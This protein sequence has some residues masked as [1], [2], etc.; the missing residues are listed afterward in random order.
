MI[1][2]LIVS[3]LF[4]LFFVWQLQENR[5]IQIKAS[6]KGNSEQFINIPLKDVRKL[7]YLFYEMF[8][9]DSGAYTLFGSKAMYMGGSIKPFIFS[10]LDQLRMSL[11]LHNY[12]I[13]Q[14]WKT[15]G[16]Y[17]HL[18]HN[19]PFIWKEEVNPFWT[20]PACSRL[21]VLINKKAF[22]NIVHLHKDDFEKILGRNEI[23]GDLLLQ[24][25]QNASLFKT[26]LKGHDG[27]IGTLFGFGRN[28]SWLFEEKKN[29]N[30]V[31]LDPLWDEK[32]YDFL[33]NRP[34]K[35]CLKDLSLV[36]GYPTFL[37]EQNTNETEVLKKN[38]IAI[39]SKI[40]DYYKGKDFLEATFRLLLEGP[41]DESETSQ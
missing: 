17:E 26:V 1:K 33:L 30:H 8:I 20:S 29:G 36:L 32:K 28:N 4:L 37:A 10:D 31:S 19:T 40:L 11:S 27:L 2:K 9:L 38:F 7:T 34:D 23:T 25:S 5:I 21:F 13:R 41:P 12:K 16:K 24:E 6:L 3:I 22:N 14:G 39:R 15:W 18:F 35:M